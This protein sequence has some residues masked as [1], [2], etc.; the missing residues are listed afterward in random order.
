MQRRD[1]FKTSLVGLGALSLAS[2][3][4]LAFSGERR[5]HVVFDFDVKSDKKNF[6]LDLY[7]P[8][9]FNSD[10]QQLRFLQIDGN[11][12]SHSINSDN[13]YDVNTHYAKYSSSEKAKLLRITMEIETKN[14]S[15]PLELI[16]KASQ[17]N[18]PIP[19]D[20]KEFLKPTEHIP[21]SGKAKAK[22]LEITQGISDTFEKVQAIYEWV[23]YNTYRDP[24][25]IGCGVGHV[26]KAMDA[27]YLGG[28]CTD[29][30]S[31]FVSFLRSVNIPAREVFGIRLGKSEYSAKALGGADAKGFAK[32]SGGQHCRTEYY[33]AGAGWI[34]CDP[35][36]IRKLILVEDLKYEDPRVQELKKRYLHSWE[37]NWVGFNWG[38][39]FT[40]SP[41]P[42]NATINNFGYPYAEIDGEAL[43]YY[44]P[45]TFSYNF[46]S[47]EI[48]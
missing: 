34:P 35:A 12:E 40:L 20:V 22:A 27:G 8:L 18:L 46:T 31:I 41:K 7:N 36:D 30:S 26:G 19:Q 13:A 11:F 33:I 48:L 10:F 24:K 28:K 15:V 29:I 21:T 14:V 43:N 25:T 2:S 17:A 5:F 45:K 42:A 23:C 38:R 3:N 47:Q 37:M 4:A 44:N 6:P 9:P 39:D 16:K 1:F 32:I